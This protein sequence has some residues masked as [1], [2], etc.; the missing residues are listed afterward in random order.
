MVPNKRIS[1]DSQTMP[2]PPPPYTSLYAS[3]YKPIAAIQRTIKIWNDHKEELYTALATHDRLRI[4]EKCHLLK[5]T[6]TFLRKQFKQLNNGE[7]ARVID[8][9]EG[10]G[11]GPDASLVKADIEIE[12]VRKKVEDVEKK[13]VVVREKVEEAG[14]KLDWGDG[15]KWKF[16][17]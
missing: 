5:G 10:I 15:S 12:R 9:V 11:L 13:M 17:K 1:T 3:P 6:F 8:I 14:V 2:N 7:V 16:W 4:T